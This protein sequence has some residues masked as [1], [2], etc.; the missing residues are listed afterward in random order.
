[1]L[2]N[3]KEQR[4]KHFE[5]ESEAMHCAILLDTTGSMTGALPRLKNSVID[6]IDELGPA[7]Y[8]AIYTFTEQLDIQQDF[9][10]DK[11]AAKRAV[12]RIRAG[13]RT[14]LFNA[15]AET[16]EK[17]RDQPGKRPSWSLPT[18]TT[19]PAS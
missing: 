8:V 11:D 4:L 10:R 13:G 3:G 14:A 18:G 2:D 16:A 1:M 5:S 15:L 6:F 19:T 17:M 9:T 7:D 12:L